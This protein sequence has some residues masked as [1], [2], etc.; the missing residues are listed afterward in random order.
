MFFETFLGGGLL[1]LTILIV[2]CVVMSA[3]VIRVFRQGTTQSFTVTVLFLATMMF[4]FIG[5]TLDSGPAAIV[6]WS[7]AASA[8]ILQR[9]DLAWARVAPTFENRFMEV[10]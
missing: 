10:Q 6:F 8:P 3:Y 5:S 9:R 2:L 1:A 4:G 7:L